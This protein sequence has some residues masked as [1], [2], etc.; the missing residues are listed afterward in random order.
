MVDSISKIIKP[1]FDSTEKVFFWLLL[2]ITTLF[3]LYI[4]KGVPFFND[5][6]IVNSKGFFPFKHIF[7]YTIHD[8]Y[9]PPLYYLVQY[10]LNLLGRYHE[11]YYR[12]VNLLFFNFFVVLLW[13]R[14]FKFTFL[15]YVPYLLLISSYFTAFSILNTN[16]VF[17]TMWLVYF[18]LEYY[19]ERQ[20]GTEVLSWQTTF[21]AM[22]CFF[23][24]YQ[25]GMIALVILVMDGLFYNRKYTLTF[26]SFQLLILS[27][28]FIINYFPTFTNNQVIFAAYSMV[29]LELMF[30]KRMDIVKMMWP[31]Q[32]LCF[33]SS[34]RLLNFLNFV[35]IIDKKHKINKFIGIE[36]IEYIPHIGTIIIL[37]L[38]IV[39]VHF[40]LKKKYIF[41][42]Q[43][44][45]IALAG[46]F[47][48]LLVTYLALRGRQI[49]G[50]YFLFSLPIIFIFTSYYLSI[51]KNKV[52]TSI[53]FSIFIFFNVISP[54]GKISYFNT[55]NSRSVYDK[56][57]S[58]GKYGRFILHIVDAIHWHRFYI[59][60]YKIKKNFRYFTFDTE[61][62][63]ELLHKIMTMAGENA[64]IATYKDDCPNLKQRILSKCEEYDSKCFDLGAEDGHVILKIFEPDSQEA[65]INELEAIYGNKS[66]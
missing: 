21:L 38:S 28:I 66:K 57:T 30:Y 54:L 8:S 42:I 43:D 16:Y 22:F 13:W 62:T 25:A 52:F 7:F 26:I 20:L 11:I 46:G 14:S 53:I 33:W 60:D 17:A 23:S 41:K 36:P 19:R 48:I 3:K 58:H 6:L 40:I 45:I 63:D 35:E 50:R 44:K 65:Q 2:L 49:Y 31:L 10:Y 29:A 5:E 61:C 15:K 39:F 64:F 12:A 55:Q 51:A 34:L 18:V 1:F 37:L 47:A 56:I 9:H 32:I 59:E 27:K 24:N 4:A